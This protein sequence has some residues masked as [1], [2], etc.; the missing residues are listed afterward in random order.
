MNPIKDTTY[1][2]AIV[3]GGPVG[4]FLA[5][6][7]Q[8]QG[9]ECAVLEKRSKRITHSRSLGIHPV[10]LELMD[11][12]GIVDDF[13]ESGI[14]IKKGVAY[15]DNGKI[16]TISF[17][18]CPKPYTFILSL[19]QFKTE[20]LLEDRLNEIAP[21]C[22]HRG[23]EVHTVGMTERS[24]E[25]EYTHGHER[26]RRT[27]NCRLLVGCDGKNSRVREEAGFSFVGDSYPDTYIMGDFTDNTIFGSDAAVFLGK[28]GLVESFPLTDNRRRWVVKTDAFVEEVT[29]TMLEKRVAGRVGHDIGEE[30]NY[31]LSSFG[32]QKFLADPM[33][34]GRIFLA[35][36]AAHI[37]SPIGGQGMNLGW[38]DAWDLSSVLKEILADESADWD[39]MSAAAGIYHSRRIK[40]ARTAIRRAELNMALGRAG[41]FSF[42]KEALVWLMLNTPLHR[43][44]AQMFTMR[45]L[46]RWP[47]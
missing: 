11:Q 34:E 45:G 12:I 7:L 28:E 4:L 17:E 43:L 16:G 23:A 46:G 25:V 36:D 6:A 19:P 10:S 5:I 2:V 47:V 41:R 42:P 38:L 18:T 26:E 1:P 22:L 31:M 33:A 32:V 15:G 39:R 3:G 13:L 27:L 24:V 14:K 30:E 21:G 8:R 44:M 29:R 40:A 37:V 9:V 20:E 35:G